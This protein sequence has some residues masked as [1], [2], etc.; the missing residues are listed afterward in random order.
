MAIVELAQIDPDSLI[1]FALMLAVICAPVGAYVAKAKRRAATEGFV[2][3]L[4]LGVLGVLIVALLPEGDDSGA[5]AGANVAT[6]AA[7]AGHI[8][9][10]AEH[11]RKALDE[12]GEDWRRWPP[13]RVRSALGGVEERCRAELKMGRS[14]FKDVSAA[15]RH[16]L[17]RPR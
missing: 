10:V 15:A 12:T 1:V 9:W 4:L 5:N 6:Q 3:G 13:K 14:E 2:L 17:L 11:F 8:A 16:Q 7:R